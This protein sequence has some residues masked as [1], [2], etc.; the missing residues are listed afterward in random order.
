MSLKEALEKAQMLWDKEK[1]HAAPI[2]AIE[3]HFGFKVGGGTVSRVIS[4]LGKFGLVEDEGQR[5]EKVYKLSDAALTILLSPPESA[6]R[7][8]AIETAALQPAIHREIWDTFGGDLPSDENLRSF[9]I[10]KRGFNPSFV[11]DF[12]A[13]FRDTL[14]FSSLLKDGQEIKQ[15]TAVDKKADPETVEKNK[16]PVQDAANQLREP[17]D[18]PSPPLGEK[19]KMLAQYT[20]PLGPNQA[21][22]VFTGECLTADDF[23]A[24]KDYVDL[25]K[26]QFERADTFAKRFNATPAA[27]RA[28]LVADGGGAVVSVI[29][30][31]MRDG[32][33]VYR[34][35]DGTE[36]LES[37]LKFP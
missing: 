25:F 34:T 17:N 32:Q 20:I 19:N 37:D 30:S 24:L 23:D 33:K 35:Q 18:P 3:T 7:L 14:A 21:T 9:L 29:P 13:N 2:T 36:Y 15:P 11:N 16:P 22:L 10:L 4:A 5:D 31:G 8:K 6:E 26:K 12:I 28:F 1:R 27:L